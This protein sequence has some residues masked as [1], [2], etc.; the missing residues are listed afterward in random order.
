MFS[1]TSSAASI[2]ISCEMG[3]GRLFAGRPSFE[4]WLEL[5]HYQGS[6]KPMKGSDFTPEGVCLHG[7]GQL[8]LQCWIA[9]YVEW[10]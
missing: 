1:S 3:A 8:W 6:K 9:T 2:L 5:S 10:N 7:M 4:W